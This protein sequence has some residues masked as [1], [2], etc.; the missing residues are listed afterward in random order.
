MHAVDLDN[1]FDLHPATEE[2][3]PKMDRMRATLK[4]AARQVAEHTPPGREQSTALTKLE[5]ALFW[6]NAAIARNASNAPSPVRP[7]PS[8]PQV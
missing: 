2:T 8:M 4:E 7:S 5:E 6:A 3:G 1:R